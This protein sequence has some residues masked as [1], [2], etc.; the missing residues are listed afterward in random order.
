MNMKENDH[1]FENV[2]LFGVNI[3]KTSSEF[4]EQTLPITSTIIHLNV[5]S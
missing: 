1:V 2:C 3:I 4:L 5:H